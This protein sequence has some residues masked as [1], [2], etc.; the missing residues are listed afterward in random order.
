MTDR[1]RELLIG[2]AE[3]CSMYDDINPEK[4][5]NHKYMTED[6]LVRINYNLKNKFRHDEIK[7]LVEQLKTKRLEM[8]NEVY[9]FNRR[10]P[11]CV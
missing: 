1:E 6:F 8:A 10:K 5:N 9:K 3:I 7:D 2:Y 11:I 4:D